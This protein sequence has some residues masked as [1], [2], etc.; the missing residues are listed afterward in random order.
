MTASSPPR[1]YLNTCRFNRPS[2]YICA[3]YS[4]NGTFLNH[5]LLSFL[6]RIAS[7]DALNLEPMLYQVIS[8]LQGSGAMVFCI[9]LN[10]GKG[11]EML[12]PCGTSTWNMNV[13]P[14][15]PAFWALQLK[16]CGWMPPFVCCQNLRS[17]PGRQQQTGQE[18]DRLVQ[19][20]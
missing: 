16:S 3:G 11:T 4:T 2:A 6:K 19:I 10:D 17:S 8:G 1:Q 7:S 9:C 20:Y 14:N 5:C 12:Q 18:A 15:M 13:S